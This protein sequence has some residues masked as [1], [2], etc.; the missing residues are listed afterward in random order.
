MNKLL[1]GLL[2][3]TAGAAVGY[4]VSKMMSDN[5]DSD[6][7]DDIYDYPDPYDEDE[8]VDFDISDSAEDLADN[9]KDAAED[10]KDAVE[11]AVD[12]AADKIDDVKD[13]VED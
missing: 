12:E 10:V 9:V 2:A 13:A 11:D 6:Y 3:A 7:E 5:G 1:L 4:V 8:S